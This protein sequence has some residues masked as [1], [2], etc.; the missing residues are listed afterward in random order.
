M[1]TY[2]LISDGIYYLFS[3]SYGALEIMTTAKMYEIAY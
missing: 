3:F 1:A 2:L